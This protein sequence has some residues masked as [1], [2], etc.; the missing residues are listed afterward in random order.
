MVSGG[1]TKLG[2]VTSNA[3][4]ARDTGD[5]GDASDASDASGTGGTSESGGYP[6]PPGSATGA[7]SMPGTDPLA[8]ARTVFDELPDLPYLPEFPAAARART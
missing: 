8:A 6:W 5:T 4:N 3:S 2:T 1:V 7:G